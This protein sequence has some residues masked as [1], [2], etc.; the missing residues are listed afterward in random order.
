MSVHPSA[1][2]AGGGDTRQIRIAK[3]A[4]GMGPCNGTRRRGRRAGRGARVVAEVHYDAV[5][6]SGELTELRRA[7]HR[8][9]EIG[10]ELPRTQEKVLAALDGLPLEVTTGRALTSV[11]AVL[12]G[13][14]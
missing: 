9:P 1:A 2:L 5:A 4:T 7:I 8:E 6:I 10:F 11:T 12:R 13:A 14:R 3:R